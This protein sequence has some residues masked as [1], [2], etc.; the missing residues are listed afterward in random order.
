[1]RLSRTAAAALLLGVAAAVFAPVPPVPAHE[2]VPGVKAVVDSVSPALPAGVTVQTV[3]SV[4]DQ[5]IVE[6]R[7]GVDLVVVGEVGEPFLRIGPQGT[8]ANVKSPTW[9]RSNDPT[10]TAVPPPSASSDPATPPSFARVSPEPSWGWFDHR[11]HRARLATAPA[12]K[13]PLKPTRLEEWEVPMRY[14]AQGVVVK[15]HREYQLPAGSFQPKV[16][17][18]PE[19]LRAV[20]LPGVVPG[21]ALFAAPGTPVVTVLGEGGEPMA[22]ISGSKVE[23][24]E[25]SPTW[26]FT[27]EGQGG[28][29]PSGTVGA[30][31]PPRWKVVGSSSQ[32]T[33]LE[34]RAQAVGAGQPGQE[35]RWEVPVLVGDRRDVI[36]GVTRWV[37]T[38]LT[39]PGRTTVR[40]RAARGGP[41]P[42]VWFAVGAG[43][44]G[45]ALVG[46][47]LLT[48]PS[49][50]GDNE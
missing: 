17:R 35:Q 4:S 50:R 38:S 27:A 43:V 15:G 46:R 8:F 14:G 26:V 23:V 34:R 3:I 44:A 28:F 30:S 37:P 5:L 36:A 11:L 1:V 33:W 25:A 29:T 32:V 47:L 42:W 2:E 20:A 10:G 9:Y 45:L 31:E 49:F 39:A 18:A 21:L 41:S 12:V 13:D 40:R 16:E 6:N 48:R 7:T 22:R 24:N 19:G